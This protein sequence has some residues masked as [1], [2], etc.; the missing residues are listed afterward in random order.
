MDRDKLHSALKN[1][2]N[3]ETSARIAQRQIREVLAEPDDANEVL[4]DRGRPEPVDP[5]TRPVD[6]PTRPPVEPEPPTPPSGWKE[7]TNM[8]GVFL[9]PVSD[10]GLLEVRFLSQG[11]SVY[12]ILN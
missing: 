9:G 3:A 12:G 4:E 8:A 5:P 2:G 7:A 10:D 1:A 11:G 6:P